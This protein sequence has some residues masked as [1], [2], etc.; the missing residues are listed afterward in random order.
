MVI[1]AEA[2]RPYGRQ[3][4]WSADYMSTSAPATS[5][6]G[7]NGVPVQCGYQRITHEDA[8]RLLLDKIKELSLPFDEAAS[9]SAR[10][11][12]QSQ[13]ARLGDD[14]EESRERWWEWLSEGVAALLV[15]IKD[16]YGLK[17]GC[18]A[19]D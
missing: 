7:I 6:E 15:Y 16:A 3:I 18:L 2:C 9:G 19:N 4:E 8:E 1:A 10:E 11:N 13:L 5:R 17:R 14:D 12:L